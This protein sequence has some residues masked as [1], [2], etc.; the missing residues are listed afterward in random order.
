[1]NAPV[2]ASPSVTIVFYIW[3]DVT[4]S[5]SNNSELLAQVQ[6]YP[7]VSHFTK[8]SEVSLAKQ[9]R[10]L[11]ITD[12]YCLAHDN[13]LVS[14]PCS[15]HTHADNK[16]FWFLTIVQTQL[17][18]TS[19]EP[20]DSEI[21]HLQHHQFIEDESISRDNAVN[22]EIKQLNCA[23]MLVRRETLTICWT[24]TIHS[25]SWTLTIVSHFVG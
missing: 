2:N 12:S 15:Q 13:L 3:L 5:P 1:M 18:K 17:E 21:L 6:S 4:I 24:L 14:I 11:H 8:L 7:M 9:L 23:A 19:F 16:T 20:Q 22:K 25:L 10:T